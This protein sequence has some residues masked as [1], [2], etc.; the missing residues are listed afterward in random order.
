MNTCHTTY[1]AKSVVCAIDLHHGFNIN[2]LDS[3]HLVEP[4]YIGDKRLLWSSST[5][6]RVFREIEWDMTEE[7]SFTSICDQD[8]KGKIVDGIKFDTRQLFKYLIHHFGLSDAVKV[9]SVQIALIVDGD[10]LDDKTGH[11]T[12]WFKICDKEAID[13]ITKRFIFNEDS[14]G[15]NLQSGKLYL[16]LAMIL[17]KYKKKFMASS[18]S[19]FPNHKI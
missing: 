8:P 13:P 14:D 5:T 16:P 3:L 17:A 12:I 7:I 10:P 6:K 15:L 19:N 4:A 1:T 18:L 11:V 2:G 9:R